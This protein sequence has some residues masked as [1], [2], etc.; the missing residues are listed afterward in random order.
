MLQYNET[1]KTWDEVG[2][3]EKARK[4]H[5]IAVARVPLA[6]FLPGNTSPHDHH[7]HQQ[8]PTR[9]HYSNRT[10]IILYHSNPTRNFL[11]NYRVAS[12]MYSSH[13]RKIAARPADNGDDDLCFG[14]D[15]YYKI[16]IAD[17]RFCS[18]EARQVGGFS[19]MCRM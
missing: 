14:N 12:R 1:T 3:Q 11:K 19:Q 17:H 4:D 10:R 16:F 6:C 8:G 7:F 15:D 18:P 5:A 2:K 13:F 9:T